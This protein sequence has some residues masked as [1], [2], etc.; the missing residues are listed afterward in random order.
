MSKLG[1]TEVTKP[2]SGRHTGTVIFLHGSGGTG[3]F[4]KEWVEM[5]RENATFPHLK[6]MYPTAPMRPYTP[7][8]GESSN[9]WFNRLRIA[10]DCEE[11]LDTL[12]PIGE[13]LK[14]V[15]NEEVKSGI[16]LNRIVVGGFSMGGAMAL[17]LAFRFV[18]EVAGVFALS[19]FLND[20]SATYKEL[21]EKKPNKLPALFYAHGDS[22]DLVDLAWGKKTF[23]TLQELGVKG[24]FHVINHT[25]HEL[26]KKEID[27]LFNW[28]DKL[29]PDE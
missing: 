27:L 29:I 1:R 9:V 17:H 4:S 19:S 21:R 23:E 7:L 10:P 15:I 24:E 12:N 20:N 26:K 28:I 5:L 25:F 3:Q 6:I 11:E 8:N 14:E 2:K 22:D 16:P 13:E 18:P